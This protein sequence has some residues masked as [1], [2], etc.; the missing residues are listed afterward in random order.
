MAKKFYADTYESDEV[1]TNSAND[2]NCKNRQECL[3]TLA[4]R[5]ARESGAGRGRQSSH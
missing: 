2:S 5:Q 3:D 4:K 1:L